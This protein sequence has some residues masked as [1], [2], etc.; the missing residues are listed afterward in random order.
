MTLHA[1]SLQRGP[2][3]FYPMD[4]SWPGS[5]DHGILQVR[6]LEWADMPSSRGIVLTRDQTHISNVSCIVRQVPYH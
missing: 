3:L 2:T 1:K 5:P 4:R 6:I